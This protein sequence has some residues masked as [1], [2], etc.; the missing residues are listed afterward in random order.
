MATAFVT[1]CQHKMAIYTPVF[2]P[3]LFLF[4][5]RVLC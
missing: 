1:V 3:F 2:L 4:L 5:L